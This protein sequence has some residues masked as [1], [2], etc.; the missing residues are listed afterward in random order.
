[1]SEQY[2][3][4]VSGQ[5]ERALARA[6][7]QKEERG[8]ERRREPPGL[9]ELD[10]HGKITFLSFGW[11]AA[12]TFNNGGHPRNTC[13]Y[14]VAILAF[15]SS[16][17]LLPLFLSGIVVCYILNN[18][19]VRGKEKKTKTNTIW[20]AIV[21]SRVFEVNSRKLKQDKSFAIC[22]L[23]CCVCVCIYM[24]YASMVYIVCIV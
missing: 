23:L 15:S 17:L 19:P 2:V 18:T 16:S 9:C 20:K 7:S 24:K 6:P 10:G 4:G 14:A 21:T 11:A 3:F 5:R 22:I 12:T 13:C 1:M 8:R